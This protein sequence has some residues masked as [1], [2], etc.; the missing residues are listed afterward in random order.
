MDD[1]D[2]GGG[3]FRSPLL[4]MMGAAVPVMIFFL[5][6]TL[7]VPMVLYLVARSRQNREGPPDPQLGIK[8]ALCFFRQLGYQFMLGGGLM[9]LYGMT[10][11]MLS[12]NREA[13]MRPALGLLVPALIV[14]GVHN[15]ALQRT[16]RIQF[17]IVERLYA[18]YNLLTTGLMGFVG[19]ILVFQ[20]LFGKNTDPEMGR[21]AWSVALVYTSAWAAQGVMF[22]NRVLDVP[23][24]PSSIIQPPST[25]GTGSV[26]GGGT[27]DAP[28][29]KPLG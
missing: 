8:V 9:I 2:G 14:W 25:G 17:P 28:W 15:L 23:P 27:A 3:G 20:S 1:F 19:I 5:F 13:V 26:A 24:P 29:T 11:K 16:N 10:S 18:G 22:L 21:I 4:M 12:G 7:V 6:M